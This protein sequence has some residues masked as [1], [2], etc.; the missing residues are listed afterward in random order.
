MKEIQDNM[1]KWKDVP[2]S[3]IERKNTVKISILCKAI[4]RFNAIP[5]KIPTA[6]FTELEWIILKSVSVVYSQSGL[7]T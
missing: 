4:Y 1:K 3:Q 5:N 2:C 7:K 6:F